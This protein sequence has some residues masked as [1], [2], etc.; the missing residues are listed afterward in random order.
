MFGPFVPR[1]SFYEGLDFINN[2][3]NLFIERV[4]SLNASEIDT[5]EE[6]YTFLHALSRYTSS[7]TVMRDQLVAILLAG[8]GEESISAIE[9]G[10]ADVNR[11]YR[12]YANLHFPPIVGQSRDYGQTPSRDS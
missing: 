6:S 3:V 9:T 4:S 10:S 11:F 8:R 7:T 1:K 2:Y 12:R 5:K